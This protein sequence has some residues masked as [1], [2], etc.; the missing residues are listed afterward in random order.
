[1]IQ[2][3]RLNC[4]QVLCRNGDLLATL[5]VPSVKLRDNVI[6][7]GISLGHQDYRVFACMRVICM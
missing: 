6:A 5:S 3:T 2:E 4:R 1:M 7:V